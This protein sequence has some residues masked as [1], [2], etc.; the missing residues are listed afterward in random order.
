ME[1][2][3]VRE[4]PL[5]A[6]SSVPALG[7]ALMSA[8]LLCATLL[9]PAKAP[10]KAPPLAQAAAKVTAEGAYATVDRLTSPEYAGRLTGTGGYEAAARWVA[11]ECKR[12]G[13][14][15]VKEYKGYL[16][17]FMVR[18]G[19]LDGATLE[20]LPG[21]KAGQAQAQAFFKD[22]MPMLQS[23]SG[24]VA[25]EV[26]FAG[27]GM[28]A[29]DLGRDDY[30]GIKAEG[31]VVMVL[32]GEPKD[33]RDWTRY[34][35]TAAREANARAHGAAAFLMIDQPVLSASGHAE[36]AMP[37]ALVSEDFGNRLLA[38][39]QLSVQD[40]RRVLEKGGTAS[41]PTG[42]TVH[43]AVKAR[44]GQDR[45]GFNVVALLPGRDK[46]LAGEYVVVGAHLDHVGSWPALCPGADD[47]A[48]GAAALLEVA[49]AAAKAKD[50]PRRTLAFVWFG[51]EELGL[52]GATQFARHPP[53]GLRYC[54]AVLNMDMVGAGTGAYV[55]GGKNFPEI[56][57][58]LESARDHYAPEMT[59]V[60]G[61]SSG[62]PRADHGPF[63][64]LGVR[65]VSLFGSGGSH[66]GYHTPGDTLYFITPKTMEAVGRTVLGAAFGL[67]DAP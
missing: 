57:N 31:K 4:D 20:I 5:R 24:D 22:F 48:S 41:F 63:Q 36:G 10:P 56:Y 37:A 51:G 12:A 60:A 58:A 1:R 55:S 44:E 52:L 19:G 43:L 3:F 25:A 21:D 67:A 65:A 28:T 30:A 47:N 23:A 50:R 17:P 2:R 33:G 54:T 15:P 49:R 29:Q 45:P 16:Q 6:S 53:E 14:Q 13:L 18:L 35:G 61:E 11:G 42:I 27:F 39:A 64:A 46:K 8:A 40:L 26:V 38:P 59:L 7:P 66:H 32:R 62:E 34:D 9:T